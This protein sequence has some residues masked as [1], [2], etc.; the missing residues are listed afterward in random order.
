MLST[1]K[2]ASPPSA[3]SP[4]KMANPPPSPPAHARRAMRVN[5]LYVVSGLIDLQAHV[6]SE[7]NG[8][9]RE[10]WDKLGNYKP[11]REPWRAQTRTN[12]PLRR[13]RK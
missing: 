5:G 1:P 6:F 4:T 8:R 2:T 13:N 3:T 11:Q 10:N 7:T 12:A 9:T